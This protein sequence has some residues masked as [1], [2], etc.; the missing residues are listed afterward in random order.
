MRG[1]SYERLVL[2]EVLLASRV[3]NEE[4]SIKTFPILKWK[5]RGS[6][7]R[8]VQI[9][10]SWR[11]PRMMEMLQRSRMDKMGKRRGLSFTLLR[12]GIRVRRRSR[13]KWDKWRRRRRQA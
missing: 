3:E 13:N 7:E 12:K 8:A 1:W 4:L 6:T 11:N 5:T 2:W 9:S 10:K